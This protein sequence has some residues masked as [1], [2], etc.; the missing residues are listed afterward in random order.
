MIAVPPAII[1][2]NDD[3]V[4]Q[5]RAWIVRQ[6]HI[7]E[8]IDG[9]VFDARVAADSSYPDKIRQLGLRLMVVRPFNELENRT[10]ADV[11]IFVKNGMAAIEKNKFGPPSCSYP[12]SNLYWGQLCIFGP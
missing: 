12:V 11:V 10:L 6:L 1:F 5:V 4:P 7:N 3:L 2:I 8:V 9:Y